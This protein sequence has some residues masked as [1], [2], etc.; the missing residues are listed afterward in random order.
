MSGSSFDNQGTIAIAL[1]LTLIFITGS[2]LVSHATTSGADVYSPSSLPGGL[3]SIAPIAHN[4]WIFRYNQPNSYNTNWPVCVKGD[5]GLVGNR[6]VVFLGDPAESAGGGN[7]NAT[8]QV[9]QMSSSQ[10][11]Y[12]NVYSGECSQAEQPGETVPQLLGC[13]QD[14]NK[15]IKLMRVTV[16][17][18]DVSSNIV[19]EDADKPFSL[20]LSSKDNSMNKPLPC[21]GLSMDENYY[22]FL[23]PFPV[24]KHTV[25]DE[26]IRVP[27]ESNQPVEHD[28]VNW[29]INVVSGR[30]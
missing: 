18:T 9:C 20:T 3:K 27:L 10:L 13:A 25:T 21:C 1:F 17:G 16:D 15:V 8:H 30:G 23:K 19:R 4:W 29:E 24:G 26:V 14:T 12:L 11:L 28:L 5:G 7:M 6:S 2:P 22:L